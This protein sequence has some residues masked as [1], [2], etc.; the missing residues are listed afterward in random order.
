MTLEKDLAERITEKYQSDESFEGYSII[1]LLEEA[2]IYPEYKELM[3]EGGEVIGNCEVW[4]HERD[5][6]RH[7]VSVDSIQVHLLSMGWTENEIGTPTIEG[8]Q[9]IKLPV[10]LS[11]KASKGPFSQ[12]L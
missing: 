10:L 4:Y 3:S 6:I 9:E 5:K 12:M 1:T 8:R 2:G 7:M 11:P